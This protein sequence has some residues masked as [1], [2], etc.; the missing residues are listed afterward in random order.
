MKKIE[1]MDTAAIEKAIEDVKIQY[2]S[3]KERGD[4]SFM[5]NKLDM[6]TE[7]IVDV[8]VRGTIQTIID[9]IHTYKKTNC[10]HDIDPA[11]EK[12]I[13]SYIDKISKNNVINRE[14]IAVKKE[15]ATAQEENVYLKK[16]HDDLIKCIKEFDLYF[17]DSLGNIYGQFQTILNK[18]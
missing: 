15:L 9:V 16:K 5:A 6:T 8:M 7:E 1:Y 13:E 3:L 11:V 18:T 12:T 2:E 17:T 14:L 4:I 10:I